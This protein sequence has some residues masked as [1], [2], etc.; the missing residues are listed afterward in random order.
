MERDA[1]INAGDL[2][3]GLSR[4]TSAVE[5]APSSLRERRKVATSREIA[6]AALDLFE[7]QGVG[8]TTVG[9]ISRAAGISERTFFRYFSSKED[10]VLDFHTWFDAPTRMWL[11]TGTTDHS[12]L[13]QLEDVCAEVLRQLDGPRRVEAMQLRRVRK[14][15]KQEPSLRAASVALDDHQAGALALQLSTHFDGRISPMEARLIA[16]MVGMGLRTACASWSALLDTGQTATLEGEHRA[17]RRT[18]KALTE[19]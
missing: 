7:R 16:E 8:A 4:G 13:E 18:V 9:D 6:E 1:Q 3:T 17:V 14:L 11:A 5:A 15:M 10:T 12:A 19:S 2:A